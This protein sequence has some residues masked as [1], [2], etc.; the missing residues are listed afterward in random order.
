MCGGKKHGE[1][2]CL[3]LLKMRYKNRAFPDSTKETE[4]KGGDSREV[5]NFN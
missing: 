4:A 2:D 1:R 3:V 5:I